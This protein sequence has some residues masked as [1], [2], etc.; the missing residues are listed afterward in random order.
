MVYII[1]FALIPTKILGT[2][3]GET[4]PLSGSKKITLLRVGISSE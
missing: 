3:H 1:S 4:S 2:S